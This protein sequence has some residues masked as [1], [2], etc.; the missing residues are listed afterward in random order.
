V[1]EH[2]AFAIMGYLAVYGQ[3]WAITPWPTLGK[4]WPTLGKTWPTPRDL[5]R[6]IRPWLQA[7]CF[8]FFR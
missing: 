1:H 4:T 2:G 8:F 6:G 5:P 3:N 7:C